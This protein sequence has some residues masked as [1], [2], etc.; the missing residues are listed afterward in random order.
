[1]KKWKVTIKADIELE[2]EFDLK[3][4]VIAKFVYDK[5]S[6]TDLIVGDDD[7]FKVIEYPD[8]WLNFEEIIE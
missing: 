4:L 1:M 3:E 2:D 6:D 7:G 8:D 5:I